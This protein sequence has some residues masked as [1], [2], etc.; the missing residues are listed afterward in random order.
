MR[1]LLVYAAHF[2][3]KSHL[4]FVPFLPILTWPMLIIYTCVKHVLYILR[5][6][7]TKYM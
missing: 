3:S 7:F 2:L 4:A 5:Y 1:G 6:I